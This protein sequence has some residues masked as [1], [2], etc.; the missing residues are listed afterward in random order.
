[1]TSELILRLDLF[2]SSVAA[3]FMRAFT[4]ELFGATNFWPTVPNSSW[5]C[6][7]LEAYGVRKVERSN[8]ELAECG[9]GDGNTGLLEP[10]SKSEKYLVIIPRP[11][12]L[13]LLY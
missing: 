2:L 3:L 13:D 6:L 7:S 8:T 5:C 11:S 4:S 12:V 1:M 9:G 10:F